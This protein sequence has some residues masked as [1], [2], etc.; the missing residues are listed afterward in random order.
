MI[1]PYTEEAA[2]LEQAI[3]RCDGILFSGGVDISP[4]RYGEEPLPP[5]GPPSLPFDGFAFS[6]FDAATRSGKP[7]LGICRGT[8]SGSPTP[9]RTAARSFLISFKCV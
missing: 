9:M 5:C 2:I 7:I 1:L 6:A 8:P 4:A 3:A